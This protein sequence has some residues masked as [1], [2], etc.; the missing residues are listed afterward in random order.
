MTLQ[1]LFFSIH[2]L[3]LQNSIDHMG[4]F[5]FCFLHFEQDFQHTKGI[6]GLIKTSASDEGLTSFA[7]QYSSSR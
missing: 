3:S 7:Q 6:R 4:F 1:A 5:V 2:E